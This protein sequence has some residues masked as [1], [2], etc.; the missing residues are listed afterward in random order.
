LQGETVAR[1]GHSHHRTF[2]RY[3]I[4]DD[5][6]AHRMP[7]PKFL[8]SERPFQIDVHHHEGHS[9]VALTGELDLATAPQLRE[10][11]ALLAEEHQ[12]H[13]VLDLASLDFIDSTGL[14]VLVMLLNRTRAVGGSVAVRHPSQPVL[15]IL[16]ITGLA[17]VFAITSA[18]GPVPS[19]QIYGFDG[20]DQ[21]IQNLSGA[22]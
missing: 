18:E 3:P 13:I 20:E 14:S 17:S 12:K 21:M 8:A 5:C 2:G 22:P 9:V 19:P 1:E 11:L 10:R 15:R 6:E 16:E 7:S 4:H